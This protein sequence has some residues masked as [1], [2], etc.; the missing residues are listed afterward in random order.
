MLSCL[1]NP[2][3]AS[4][5]KLAKEAERTKGEEVA[6]F[7]SGVPTL[8]FN[9]LLRTKIDFWEADC[10]GLATSS[11]MVGIVGFFIGSGRPWWLFPWL[12]S[13]RPCRLFHFWE[14]RPC[15]LF[16]W[17]WSAGPCRLFQW[18]WDARPCWLLPWLSG[19]R[20]YWLFH[21][22]GAWT[23]DWHVAGV[24]GRLVLGCLRRHVLCVFL[25]VIIFVAC[26]AGQ[27]RS[28]KMLSSWFA[29]FRAGSEILK[30]TALKLHGKGQEI[31]FHV[32]IGL[33]PGDSNR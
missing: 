33:Y 10:S 14:T 20:L 23:L 4:V 5:V 3:V 21:G 15:W 25:F 1:F 11:G 16:P 7:G 12:W 13:A 24:R 31:A 28:I 17:L 32:L 27:M 22:L 26:L 29:M 2:V 19:A 9:G 6:S 18:L 30:E 8:V